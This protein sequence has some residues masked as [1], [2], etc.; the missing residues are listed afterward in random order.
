L[1]KKHIPLLPWRSGNWRRNG[2]KR[3]F[4]VTQWTFLTNHALVL[5]LIAKNPTIT[6]LQMAMAI[7]ITERAVRKVIAELVKI[8]YI[9]KA[10]EGR[11]VR[12][13]VNSSMPLRHPTHRE[14][15][16]VDFLKALGWT[17]RKKQ[18]EGN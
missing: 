9:N 11:G 17:N 1:A 12:Y 10:R 15:A 14:V 16:V 13:Q 2:T 7:G 4:P 3:R 5:S 6:A 18:D 8:G